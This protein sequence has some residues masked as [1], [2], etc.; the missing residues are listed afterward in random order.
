LVAFK[1]NHQNGG[2]TLAGWGCVNK[3]INRQRYYIF[4]FKNQQH[5][6]KAGREGPQKQNSPGHGL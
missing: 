1:V 3:K 2:S 6:W 5:A 4:F